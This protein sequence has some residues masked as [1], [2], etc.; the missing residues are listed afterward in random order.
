MWFKR[1]TP[2]TTWLTL[3]V[4]IYHGTHRQLDPRDGVFTYLPLPEQ[5]YAPITYPS[6]SSAGL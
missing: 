6:G 3:S 1:P 2:T 5:N 4:L